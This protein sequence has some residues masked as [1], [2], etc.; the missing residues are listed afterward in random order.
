MASAAARCGAS[1][2]ALADRFVVFSSVGIECL[3][4]GHHLHRIGNVCAE[5]GTLNPEA[6]RGWLKDGERNHPHAAP[7]AAVFNCHPL[8]FAVPATPDYRLMTQDDGAQW[9]A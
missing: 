2:Y 6:M 5:E 7:F 4:Q 8:F 3:A 1:C 9:A